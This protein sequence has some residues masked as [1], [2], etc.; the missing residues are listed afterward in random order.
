M[1]RRPQYAS[2]GNEYQPC[3]ILQRCSQKSGMFDVQACNSQHCT[4]SCCLS[5][6]LLPPLQQP[7]RHARL[8]PRPSMTHCSP[9]FRAAACTLQGSWGPALDLSKVLMAVRQL[10]AEPNPKDPLVVDIVSTAG[11]LAVWLAGVTVQTLWARPQLTCCLMHAPW[12]ADASIPHQGVQEEYVAWSH[13][14]LFNCALICL[15]L[16]T[17]PCSLLRRSILHHSP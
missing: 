14:V 1:P 15:L 12:P 5:D 8:R 3:N 10:L 17:Q 6:R 2:Q 13:C 11:L 7:C 4:H 9:V 16:V